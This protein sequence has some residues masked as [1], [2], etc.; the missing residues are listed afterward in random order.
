MRFSCVALFVTLCVILSASAADRQSLYVAAN[1]EAGFTRPVAR[2]ESLSNKLPDDVSENVAYRGHR[3]LYAQLRYGSEN[4]R[5]VVV[6]VDEVS[7]GDFDLYVDQN[8]DRSIE[9]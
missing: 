7:S 2:S 4:S 8:R 3:R 6:V 1:D 9:P 5:Q